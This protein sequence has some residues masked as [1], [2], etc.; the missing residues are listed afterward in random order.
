MTARI[1]AG[2][3]VAG[4]ITLSAC[5]TSPSPMD[6]FRSNWANGSSDARNTICDGVREYGATWSADIG[7]EH[8]PGIS[9]TQ[10]ASFLNE[11]C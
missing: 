1:A 6:K 10:L 3:L 4:L 8:Y 11:V 2:A 9:V 7:A 5:G